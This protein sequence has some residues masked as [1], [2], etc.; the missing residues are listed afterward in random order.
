MTKTHV[1]LDE[2]ETRTTEA[3]TRHGASPKV[4]RSVAKAVRVAEATGNLICG[5]Y[6][7]ESYCQQLTTER[8]NGTVEPVVTRPKA[9]TVQVNAG[10]GFAQPAFD[11]GLPDALSAASDLGIAALS[12]HHSHTCTSMGFFTEQIAR[13]GMIGIG[14]TNAPACVAPPGGAKPVLGTNPISMAVPNSDGGIGFAFDQSTSATAIGKVRVAASKG[15]QVP[16]GWII[17]AEGNPTTE[18][19]DMSSLLSSA[20]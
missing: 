6:Y 9:A 13:A 17:D 15:E 4:A 11:A 8:V 1:T 16:E 10:F 12:I 20:P 14:M 2:I 18:P 5:L 19:K 3:L 7:L